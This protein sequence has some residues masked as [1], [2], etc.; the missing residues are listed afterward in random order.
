MKY[1]IINQCYT[2]GGTEVQTKREFQDFKRRGI[3][4]RLITLDCSLDLGESCEENHINLVGKEDAFKFDYYRFFIDRGLYKRLVTYI[5]DFNPDYIH[6]NN[7]FYSPRAVYK[8]VRKY[9]TFQTIRDFRVVCY[10]NVCIHNDYTACFGY[11]YDN[12]FKK[13]MPHDLKEAIKFLL[14]AIAIHVNEKVRKNACEIFVCPSQCLTEYCNRHG[15]KTICVNN[16]FDV[17][18]LDTFKKQVNFEKRIILFYGSLSKF[19][20][21]EQLLRAF[22]NVQRECKNLELHIVGKLDD[23]VNAEFFWEATRNESIKYCGKQKYDFII[24]KLETVFAVIVPSLWLENYPNTALEGTIT[25][26]IVC[27]S[28]RGGIPEFIVDDRCKFDVLHQDEIEDTIRYLSVV[29]QEE[30]IE[31][32]KEQKSRF[33]QNNLQERYYSNIMK[34]LKEMG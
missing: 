27:G 31:I 30:Y 18:L 1:L 8:A 11:K 4:V 33:L 19:K 22:L 12:C 2:Y 7:I 10:K 26:C 13:C 6:L 14:K 20:G 16:P 21:V 32:C 9:R 5:T 34:L 3:D 29:S 25:D 28:N 24:K 17:S 15:Y 23:D